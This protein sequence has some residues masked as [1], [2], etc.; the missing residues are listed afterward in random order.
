MVDSNKPMNSPLDNI[1][2]L[3]S[4]ANR[5]EVLEALAGAPGN[6]DELMEELDITRPTLGRI[7]Q[8]LEA[9]LWIERTDQTHGI[10]PLGAMV[11]DAFANLL[12]TMATECRLREVMPWFPAEQLPFD[13]R[14]LSGADIVV[15]TETNIMAHVQRG[16][17]HFRSAHRTRVV[18]YQTAPPM[19]KA[20]NRAVAAHDQR[21]EGILA[22]DLIE[23]LLDDQEMAPLF[24]ELLDAPSVEVYTYDDEIPVMLFIADDTVGIPLTDNEGFARAVVFSED[25]TVFDWA[26]ETFEAF[27]AEAARVEPDAFT[28]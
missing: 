8:D 25:Q 10:T 9:R 16:V 15:P 23:T 12:D 22:A 21:F 20:T 19:V 24:V 18:S 11:E 5:V 14:C 27:R 13:L 2:F 7:L 3:A 4:S 26:V 17:E 6:R 28:A 1:A